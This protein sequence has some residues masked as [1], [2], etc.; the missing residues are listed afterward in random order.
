MNGA[1]YDVIVIG[2]GAM[3]SAATYHLAANGNRVLGLDRFQP[4]HSLGSS[5]GRTRI[6]RE[7]YFEDPSYVPLVQRA[8]ELWKA[9]EKK[10]NRKLLLQT[11]GLMIGPENGALVTG[12]LRSARE[13]KLCHQMLSASD[14]RQRYSI[15][16]TDGSSVAVWE[17]RAGILFPELIIQTHLELAAEHGAC[18]K[19]NE[20]VLSWEADGDGV[21]IITPTHRYRA[22]RL[23]I[24]AG[25]WLSS[26]LNPKSEISNEATAS[27]KP[28]SEV[29]LPLTVERQV[30]FLFEP[31]SQTQQFQPHA[32]PVYIWEYEPGRFFYGFP[33]LGDGVKVAFHHQ[34][35]SSDP[36][37]VCREVAAEE[38]DKMRLLLGRYLPLAAGRLRSNAVCIYTNTPDEHFIFD[39]HPAYQQVLVAS[40]CSGHGFKFS[41]TIGELAADLLTGRKV[42][43]DLRRF[44]IDRF[45]EA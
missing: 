17:P 36:E 23:L 37:H 45:T 7:A 18:L 14:L 20:P 19:L 6:I 12:A 38:I 10:S 26:L 9:L 25:A 3:G 44:E 41:S 34:G 1:A 30:L 42:P 28:N 31:A 40:P 4:P 5:H 39:W 29:T 16:Q 33:D 27:S 2:L 24:A 15:F 43:F 11:G 22:D 32:C 21:R 8:Y 35:Q 13:H